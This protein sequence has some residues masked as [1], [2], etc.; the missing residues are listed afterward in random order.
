MVAKALKPMVFAGSSFGWSPSGTAAHAL[1]TNTSVCGT[2]STFTVKVRVSEPAVLV[3]VT[4][5]V[6]GLIVPAGAVPEST[7][8]EDSDSQ[9]G[10]ALAPVPGVKL[11]GVVPV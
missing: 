3:A 5:N 10:G 11:I 8:V 1:F 4:W 6:T 2:V 7:P 9:A